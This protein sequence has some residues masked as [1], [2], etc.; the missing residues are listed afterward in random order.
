MLALLLVPG[1]TCLGC[2]KHI[3]V[4]SMEEAIPDYYW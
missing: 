1:C 4:R 2:R 3:D